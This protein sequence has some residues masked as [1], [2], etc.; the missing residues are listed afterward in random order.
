MFAELLLASTIQIGP[1]WQQSDGGKALCP[2][3]SS[4]TVPEAGRSAQVDT[5]D[6]LWPLFTSHRDW[7]R[8]C[9]LA[10]YQ[11]QKDGGWQF[12]VLPLWFNGVD[13]KKG[14]YWGLFPLW[15][16]HPHFLFVY[17]LEFCLWPLWMRYRMP[18]PSTPFGDDP[19]MTSNAVLF[20]FFHWRDDG[21]WGVWPLCGVGH[22]RESDHA[23]A[24]WPIATWATYRKDRDTAGAGRSWMLWPL[25]ASVERERES[26]WSFIPPLFS[27]AK[28][29]S[30]S[31]IRCPWPLFELERTSSR[32]RLSVFPLYERTVSKGYGDGAV[33]ASVTRFGWRLAE[34]YFDGKGELEESRVFPFWTKNRDFLRI[35]P[36]WSSE[37]LDRKGEVVRSR[38][39]ELFPIRWVDAID[40][41]LAPY[42][43]F[44]ES[45]SNPIYT[46]HSLF[47]GLVK[48]RT[49]GK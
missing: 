49:Y 32:D 31:R 15:G 35:W 40:R 20:P 37:S 16:T 11:E 9:L 6:V 23:Y 26:Q 22:Q 12:D 42:W 38:C 13:P 8:F 46:D 7:W 48:W 3:W 36:F 39:L 18:R 25:W 33:E 29:P 21:S 44:Y 41:N 30:G 34:F 27:H 45:V 5:T 28:T 4:K 43:T 19:W 14:S 47:W 2:F 1:F 10:H 24:L 17:D